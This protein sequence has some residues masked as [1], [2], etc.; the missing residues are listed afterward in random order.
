MPAAVTRNLTIVA[1][2]LAVIGAAL[3]VPIHPAAASPG[4]PAQVSGPDW[5]ECGDGLQCATLS[6][7]LDW[8]RPDGPTTV[9]EL[10][11]LP[12]VDQRARRGTIVVVTGGPAPTLPVLRAFPALFAELRQT[13]DIVGVDPRG[14]GEQGH[15]PCPNGLGPEAFASDLTAAGWQKLLRLNRAWDANCRRTTNPV[16]NHLNAWQV[17]HDLDAV[18]AALGERKLD[19]LGN[20]YGAVYAQAYL[21]LFPRR[22]GRMVLDSV[23]DHTRTGLV[24]WSRQ[25]SRQVEAKFGDYARWCAATTSCALH[26]R[27]FTQVWDALMARAAKQPLPAP[28]AGADVTVTADEV[29]LQ[30]T[31]LIDQ[32]PESP[33]Y[34]QLAEAI[35]EAERGDAA[36]FRYDSSLADRLINRYAKCADFPGDHS[37]LAYVRAERQLRPIAPRVGWLQARVEFALCAGLTIV[38]PYPTH[39]LRSRGV[40]PVLLL[41]GTEDA[42]TPVADGKHVADQ[43]PGSSFITAE[44]SNHGVYLWQNRCARDHVH[45]FYATGELPPRRTTCPPN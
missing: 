35:V 41:G 14:I 8:R 40:P 45:R 21:E 1:V 10:G 25:R 3:I 4:S 18:R 6:T 13:Y 17:A 26:G 19:Y 29:R 43:L 28:S 16:V 34:P 27:D 36:K 9:V 33:G 5:T 11:R 2:V 44:G 30:T 37:Y 15:Y 31:T 42:A 32:N 24:A 20:S 22:A 12:A 23:P 39:P 7:P 38:D